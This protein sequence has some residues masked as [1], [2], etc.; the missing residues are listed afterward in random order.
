MAAAS[1]HLALAPLGR[2]LAARFVE[3]R[4][5]K[6]A[7]ALAYYLLFALFPLMVFASNLLGLMDVNVEAVVQ[8]LARLLPAAVVELVEGYLGY[9]TQA[10]SHTL[11]VFSLVF[12][13]WFPLR[14]VRGLTGD[15]RLAYGLG[16]PHRVFAQLA[17]Q[18][19]CTAVLLVVVALTLLLTVMGRHVIELVGGLFSQGT[20]PVSDYL[21]GAWQYARFLPIALLM[22]AALG[23]LYAASLDERPR[24]RALAPGIVAALVSWLALSAGFSAY[25]EHFANYTVVYGTLGAVIVLLVWLYLTAVVLIMG[26]ELNA[27]LQETHPATQKGST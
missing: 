19:A 17:R 27:A 9:V 14:A 26:A 22:L 25:V 1:Q 11:L 5:S 2:R 16:R 6:S 8:V 12:S 20:V 18:L 24:L 23:I 3:H 7:A 4:V 10:S 21:L 15:V 13:I